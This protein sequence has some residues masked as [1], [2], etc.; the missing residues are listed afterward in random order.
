MTIQRTYIPAAG[1]SWLLPIYDPWVKLLGAAA[2]RRALITQM[3]L[4]PGLRVLDI[5]SGTGTFAVQLKQLHPRITVLG[6]DPDPRAVARAETKARNAGVEVHFDRAFADQL[7][8]ADSSFDRVSCT[9]MLSLVP[10]GEKEATLTEVRRVLK[11]TGSFHLL[12]LVKQPPRNLF[13]RLLQPRK[14]LHTC[15]DDQIVA[16]M[17]HAGF[18]DPKRTGHYALWLWPLATYRASR[19]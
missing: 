16:L 18:V 12:D 2:L 5:G 6:L 3:T 7:P 10:A 19:A 14:R 11:P 1:W 15:T 9:F 8:Y 17:R 4:A 13:A